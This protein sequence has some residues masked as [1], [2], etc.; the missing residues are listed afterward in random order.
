[1]RISGFWSFR[2]ISKWP[3]SEEFEHW[4][5]GVLG[6]WR[7]TIPQRSRMLKDPRSPRLLKKVQMSLDFARDREPAERQGGTRWAE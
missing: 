2:L 6:A 5:L 7:Y 1:V 4:S 3:R